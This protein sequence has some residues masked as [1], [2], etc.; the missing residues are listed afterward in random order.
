[1]KKS[2]ILLVICFLAL[3][4]SIVSASQLK[5]TS[6]HPFLVNNNWIPA[7]QLQVG[8]KLKTSD[9]K[10]V[11]IKNITEVEDRV[12]VYNLEA[13]PYS[14]F[15]VSDGVIVHNSK[16]PLEFEKSCAGRSDCI[17]GESTVQAHL[18]TGGL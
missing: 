14:D 4:F 5:V 17:F 13:S 9:G 1:M 15:V 8:D 11:V 7:S 16:L 3:S 12:E 10:Q 6:E 2:V 18:Q